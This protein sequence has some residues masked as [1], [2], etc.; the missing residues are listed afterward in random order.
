MFTTQDL[1]AAMK[2]DS[3]SRHLHADGDIFDL[4]DLASASGSSDLYKWD[5][6]MPTVGTTTTQSVQQIYNKYVKFLNEPDSINEVVKKFIYSGKFVLAGGMVKNM[7]LYH[8]NS[9]TDYDLFFVGKTRESAQEIIKDFY[10]ELQSQNSDWRMY[11][12]YN[13]VTITNGVTEFQCILRLYN[14][15]SELL[16][17]FDVGASQCAWT[18]N[19]LYITSMGRVAFEQGI[20]VVNLSKRRKTHESRL[21]KYWQYGFALVFPN[22]R[23]PSPEQWK[24][25]WV[26]YDTRAV[27]IGQ[28]NVK[29]ITICLDYAVDLESVNDDH[30][31]ANGGCACKICALQCVTWSYILRHARIEITGYNHESI[32][33]GVG[34]KSDKRVSMFNVKRLMNSDSDLI[35]YSSSSGDLNDSKIVFD[36]SDIRCVINKRMNRWLTKLAARSINQFYLQI[37]GF[38]S[39][40][41]EVIDHAVAI[42]MYN[43]KEVPIEKKQEHLDRIIDHLITKCQTALQAIKPVNPLWTDTEGTSNTPGFKLNLIKEEEWYENWYQPRFSEQQLYGIYRTDGTIVNRAEDIFNTLKPKIMKLIESMISN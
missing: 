42:I 26:R 5:Y 39:W 1:L 7:L 34:Y 38:E 41:S 22:L 29:N 2:N 8:F 11:V 20:N 30:Y 28:I 9:S 36:E 23:E 12:N 21:V 27:I 6:S 13:C 31:N 25:M 40:K 10:C 4:K 24:K 43:T 37:P 19:H 18:G 15:V 17:G 3:S 32:Y 33:G 35:I 16:H 14:T